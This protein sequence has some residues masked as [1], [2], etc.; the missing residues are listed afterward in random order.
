MPA[1]I[2]GGIGGTGGASVPASKGGGIGGTGGVSMPVS[3]GIGVGGL[4]GPASSGGGMGEMI[5]VS[6]AMGAT[7][8]QPA[9]RVSEPSARPAEP[10]S[11][12]RGRGVKRDMGRQHTRGPPHLLRPRGPGPAGRDIAGDAVPA[13]DRA[14]GRPHVGRPGMTTRT[15]H[16]VSLGC[17]KNRVDTEVMLGVSGVSGFTAV[18]RPED[19][20]V[21]VVN[22]CGFVGEA[23]EESIE[24]ILALGKQKDAGAFRTL[25]VAGCL[26]QRYP[27]QLAA[28]M[29]EV[30]HFLGS[31]DMLKLEEVLRHG[32]RAPRM[33]VGNPADWT[34]R[35]TDP[36]APSLSR[37]F[38]YVKIA[39]G[40][41]KRCAFCA[42]PTFRGKQR[43][44][45][46]EDVVR[47]CE[48]HIAHGVK[49]LCLISQDTISYGRD[50]DD[51]AK[52]AALVRRVADLPGAAWVRLFYLYPENLDPALVELLAQH[53]K[54]LRYVDMPLQHASDRM[55]KIM[56]RGHGRD[57]QRRVVDTVKSKIEG[58]VFRS[59]FIVG[60][61][62]E[63]EE[64]FAELVDFVG[65]AELDRVA[66]FQYSH[67]EDTKAFELADD[68][69][70]S[71]K[72]K[73]AQ[74]L[75]SIQR[76]IGKKKA[77]ALVGRELEVIVE[78]IS[79]ESEL[80]LE[81]R[82]W[83][84]APE[85][86]GKVYLANGTAQPG[87]LR[88]ALVTRAVDPDLVA[89]LCEPDGSL[90]EPPPGAPRRKRLPVV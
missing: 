12:A 35:A 73:R 26:S 88:K 64:D 20:E 82:W 76:A 47:E 41:N 63:T 29:P 80:L 3:R 30:D 10:K 77:K 81:G 70:A 43:S 89:D 23:K 55:L 46:I 56:R 66:V 84:Q 61:P 21:V 87:E 25:V 85:I 54:V 11:G 53:P 57:R 4:S 75:L 48:E 17:A 6:G 37:H 86:D 58:A 28:E 65:W 31:S 52:L 38:A 74:K 79:D 32:E 44:R 5:P 72:K 36:R 15:I 45:S 40:C 7:A 8:P 1:S 60:H 71:V 13:L 78:G 18:P 2:G 9:A 67:E 19:A 51:G 49:E 39:E 33:L 22:T 16:F 14:A 34:M 50:R 42:I 24:T 69:P 62:G 68:V 27:E 90:A 59:A 83:G